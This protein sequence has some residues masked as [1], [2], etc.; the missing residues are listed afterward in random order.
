MKRRIAILFTIATLASTAQATPPP[1]DAAA[2]DEVVTALIRQLTDYYIYPDQAAL[3]GKALRAKQQHG[4]Y[5]SIDNARVFADMLT[6][7][8]RAVSHDKHLQVRTSPTPFP[9]MPASP[10]EPT[11]GQKE[12]ML[13]RMTERNFS[14]VKV[15]IMEGNIGYLDMRAF[16]RA[17][18]AAPAITAAMTQ[19]ADSTALIIDMRQN[20][21]GDPA[22]VAF[23]ASYLFEQR[24]HLNDLYWREGDR[25]EAFWTDPGVPGKHF[26]QNKKLYVL[27]G[28]GTFSGGEE[29]S[30]DMQQLKR[31]TLVGATT[32]GGANPGSGRILTPYFGAF[33]PSGRAVNPITKTSWEGTGVVPDIAVPVG[34]ALA[35]AHRLALAWVASTTLVRP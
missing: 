5:N 31:A 19:L 25:T 26:G 9:P 15:E 35:T 7:D 17:A 8:L 24:T 1:L 2:R 11:P 18:F 13:K 12:A 3:M 14:I 28:P 10:G 33:I 32:G 27:T 21:G 29:F 20:G 16:E 23:L 6:T 34:D 30:Y 22:S 4:D